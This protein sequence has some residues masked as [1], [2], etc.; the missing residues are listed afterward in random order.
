MP[1][2]TPFLGGLDT[3][4][5]ILYHAH[6]LAPR[7]R[8]N[9]RRTAGGAPP[10]PLAPCAPPGAA[11]SVWAMVPTR[12]DSEAEA[13]VAPRAGASATAGPSPSAGRQR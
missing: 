3:E 8:G 10:E 5:P 6:G 11:P 1:V 13:L 2:F 7:A 4:L 12:A 9:R